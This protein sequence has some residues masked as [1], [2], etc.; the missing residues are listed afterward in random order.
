MSDQI[1]IFSFGRKASQRCP[2]KMLRPFNGTTLIDIL[3]SKLAHFG[4]RAFFAG[5][6]PEFKE[7]CLA[8][9]V[10]FVARDEKSVQIDG[11]ITEILSFLKQVEFENLLIVNA[12]L[13]LLRPETIKSFI[14]H[15]ETGGYKP[16]FAVN[17]RNNFFITKD[18][19]P[20]NFPLSL[21]TINTKAV[22]P[23][24]EFAHALYFFNKDYFFREGRYWDWKEVDLFPIADKTELI[25]IDTEE[26]FRIAECA[27]RALSEKGRP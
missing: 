15:C 4:N 17:E 9:G 13:P 18:R 6:E 3:L 11:P 14:A 22:Q 19:K 20:L 21:R 16:C 25:D 10:K 26:D 1:G 27:W 24:Y 8:H 7:K 12:C 5:Y 2:N 23:I